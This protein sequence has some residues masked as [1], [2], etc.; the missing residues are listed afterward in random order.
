MK[1]EE[2]I[3]L[4]L[5]GTSINVD[6]DFDEEFYEKNYPFVKDYFLPLGSL[7]SKRKRLFYHYLN[8][9][10]NLFK[11][12]EQLEVFL[13]GKPIN[14]DKD[15]DEEFY[16]KKYPFVKDYFMPAAALIPKKKRFFHHYLN[17][18]EKMSKTKGEI[19]IEVTDGLANRLRTLNSFYNF[20]QKKQKKL[21]V[22]WEAGPGYSDEG[23]EKFFHNKDIKFITK[24]EYNCFSNKLFNLNNFVYK[25]KK[26]PDKYIFELPQ[27]ELIR[28]INQESFCYSG[29][30]CLEYMFP[31]D[32]SDDEFF[33]LKLKNNINLEINKILDSFNENTIG[34]H[35][36]RGDAWQ[37][38][39][40]NNFKLSDDRS[41]ILKMKEEINKDKNVKFFLS[42][43]CRKTQNKFKK[44]FRNKIIVNNNKNFFNSKNINSLKP[45]Q[46]DAVID[47][48]LLSK[49]KKIFG[50]NWSSFSYIASKI[51]KND[52]EII[53]KNIKY[54]KN[55]KEDVSVICAVKNRTAS[56]IVSLSSWLLFENIKEIIIVDWS[57]DNSLEFLTNKDKRVKVIRVDNQKYFHLSK[58]YNLALKNAQCKWIMK[59]DA[60]YI[61]NT[62][63]NFFDN[64]EL[65]K[66]YFL[67]GAWQDLQDGK[68]F[69][70]Y[71]NGFIF[72]CRDN[73]L[74]VGGY[75][76]NLKNYGY[77]DEDLYKRL[78][79]S[80][81]KRIYLTHNPV[82]IIHMPH[83]GELRV[84]NYEIKDIK[85]SQEIN[86][87]ISNNF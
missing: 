31:S 63:F 15:F 28:L 13:F 55:N 37:S 32:F 12:C 74:K 57:S 51:G 83:S 39:W 62:S 86:C 38:P 80:G 17:Y 73:L 72:T 2:K 26:N 52:L 3:E 23:F 44:L 5:F 54:K 25:N 47:L 78:S 59:M 45:F 58:A 22:C 48:I 85:K 79:D 53:K 7:I 19:Y 33:N 49:T 24:K 29:N 65:E 67:T 68:G 82:D 11:N 50:S 21:F 43:D 18:G 56:L 77:D 30:S 84:E 60:E 64:Y 71:L 4:K 10:K 69:F 66:K 14:V 27:S 16:E 42:T 87:K 70:S 6:E 20:S 8:Y 61:L 36:R 34:V 40:K 9:G 1:T 41:F 76:E 46:K 35:I 75:N 81:L